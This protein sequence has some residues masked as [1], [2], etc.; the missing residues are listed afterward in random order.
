MSPSSGGSGWA[1]AGKWTEMVSAR[2]KSK[3]MMRLSDA[4]LELD[5]IEAVLVG[6]DAICGGVVVEVVI[7]QCD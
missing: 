2:A 5:C 3:E 4:L 7:V 1:I 6:T